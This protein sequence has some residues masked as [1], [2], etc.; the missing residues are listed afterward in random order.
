VSS[1]AEVAFEGH[2]ALERSVFPVF[3]RYAAQSTRH[4]ARVDHDVVGGDATWEE[5]G[6]DQNSC[7]GC[8]MCFCRVGDENCPDRKKL[9]KL[10]RVLAAGEVE[11]DLRRTKVSVEH[12]VGWKEA[13]LTEIAAVSS[14][15]IK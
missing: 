14:F 3:E 13:L 1:T 5:V 9:A 7:D 15:T 4:V 2:E 10:E 6:V 8:G 11:L 12:R